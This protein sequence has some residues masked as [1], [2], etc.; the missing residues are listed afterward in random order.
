MPKVA[1]VT[2]STASLPVELLEKHG[3]RVVPLQVVMGVS[4]YEDGV[5]PEASPSRVAAAMRESTAVSTSR[6]SPTRMLE[7]YRELAELG[8]EEIVSVHLSSAVSATSESASLAAKRSPVPVHVVDSCLVGPGTGYAALTAAEVVAADGTA[9]E[10]AAAARAR[11]GAST[12]LFYVDSL[13]YLRRG[14][15]IGAAAALLGSA[16]AVKPILEVREGQV[17]PRE[18]VRTKARA[19]MKLEELAVEA[20]G[21]EPVDVAVCHLTNPEQAA[22]LAESLSQRLRDH[23]RGRVVEV[24][25]IGA[26][27]GAHVG[28]GLV[29][30][31]VAPLLGSPRR[32]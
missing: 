2:D 1:V 10:A 19:L 23:M 21:E 18:K 25:E 4:S 32:G 27:L 8:A 6:P 24:A 29:G 11:A 31:T 16:L 13:E 26:V 7:V 14:G 9:D 17:L 5:D 15:R 28:P 3:V 12:T 30:V 20:A 22:L